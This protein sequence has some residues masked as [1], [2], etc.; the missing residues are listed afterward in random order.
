MIP[1]PLAGVVM[2][3]RS[4]TVDRPARLADD[5]AVNMMLASIN[6]LTNLAE[7]IYHSPGLNMPTT[8]SSF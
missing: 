6:D 4:G 3:V 1:F 5:L 7:S 2:G 8:E